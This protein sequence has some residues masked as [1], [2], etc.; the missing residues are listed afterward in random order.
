MQLHIVDVNVNVINKMLV[1]LVMKLYFPGFYVLYCPV[2]YIMFL[3]HNW[4]RKVVDVL[5]ALWELY[6]VVS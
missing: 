2:L 6:P 3:N 1:L 4:Y 5:F